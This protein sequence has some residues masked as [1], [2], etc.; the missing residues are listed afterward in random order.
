MGNES[1]EE[2]KNK[3]EM[4]RI[5]RKTTGDEG[6]FAVFPSFIQRTRLHQTDGWRFGVEGFFAA[7]FC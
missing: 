5:A 6:R 4:D 7:R 1:K 3:K 2:N